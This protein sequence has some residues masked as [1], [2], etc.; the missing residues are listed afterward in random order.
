MNQD[1]VSLL[2]VDDSNVV[3][4]AI[5]GLLAEESSIVILG[6]PEDLKNALSMATSF[7]QM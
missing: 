3:R 6:E 4:N 2:I 1:T 7:S 5:R